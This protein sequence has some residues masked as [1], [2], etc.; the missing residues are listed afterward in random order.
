MDTTLL[1]FDTASL[2]LGSSQDME[3]RWTY[4]E[5]EFVQLTVSCVAE[6]C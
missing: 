6:N 4:I 1:P 2:D 5:N 3:E